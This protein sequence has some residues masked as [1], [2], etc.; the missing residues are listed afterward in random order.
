MYINIKQLNNDRRK[1]E[2]TREINIFNL[3]KGEYWF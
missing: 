1:R 3:S 2:I